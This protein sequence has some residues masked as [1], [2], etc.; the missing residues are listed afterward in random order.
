[1]TDDHRPGKQFHERE[2]SLTAKDID[3]IMA[4]IDERH[5]HVCRFNK[6][7]E[8]EFYESVKFFKSMNESMTSGRNL[9]VKT[10]I[11]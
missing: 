2:R 1:M 6:I 11:V 4:A 10:A 7:T 8:E 9:A 3:A 5:G